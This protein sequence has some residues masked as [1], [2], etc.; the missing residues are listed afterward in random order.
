M[1]Q[2][3]LQKIISRYYSRLDKLFGQLLAGF[4]PNRI[5]DFRVEFKKFRALCRMLRNSPDDKL[6]IPKK[7]RTAYRNTG[8]LRDLQ[9]QAERI[10]A[11][12]PDNWHSGDRYIQELLDDQDHLKLQLIKIGRPG[13]SGKKLFRNNIPKKFSVSQFRDYADK[14]W[15]GIHALI[16]MPGM[17]EPELHQIRKLLKDLMYNRRY[18]PKE[19]DVLQKSQWKKYEIVYMDKLLEQ[20]GDFQD[21]CTAV[22]LLNVF[23]LTGLDLRQR[24][25]F[26]LLKQQWSMNRDQ[27]RNKL[28]NR[29]HKNLKRS[30]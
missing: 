29:L 22:S 17:S 26:I 10:R 6:P 8:A 21:R 14:Q 5:H 27:L 30:A 9:L 1:K 24:E 28:I 4:D 20:L 12:P 13:K 18:F 7:L 25:H 3:T 19:K 23:Y 2:K 11:L 16:V 15:A